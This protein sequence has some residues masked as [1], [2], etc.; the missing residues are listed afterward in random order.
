MTEFIT[1]DPG[2]LAAR[3]CL[4]SYYRELAARFSEGFDPASYPTAADDMRPPAGYLYLAR[5]GGKAVACAALVL[6][7]DDVAEIRRMW[8][9]EEMRGQGLAR[10]LLQYLEAE[11]K[12]LGRNVIRLDTNRALL[13]AQRMYRNAGYSEI[14]RFND[15]PYAHHWFEK[16]L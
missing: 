15:N 3:H 1:E 10:S 5:D 8:V 13:V 7:A 4:G 16:K 14:A 11:A 2:S 9:A 6:V 12:R